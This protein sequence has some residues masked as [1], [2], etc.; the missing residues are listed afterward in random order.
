MLEAGNLPSFNLQINTWFSVYTQNSET[1][2]VTDVS[3]ENPHKHTLA[4]PLVKQQE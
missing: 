3:S 4:H 1:M 2:F